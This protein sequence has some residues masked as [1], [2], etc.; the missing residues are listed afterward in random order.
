MELV[1]MGVL[2]ELGGEEAGSNFRYRSDMSARPSPLPFAS[3][4]LREKSNTIS[5]KHS[6]HHRTTSTST[7]AMLERRGSQHASAVLSPTS[8]THGRSRS[9][10]GIT[11]GGGSGGSVPM[12]PGASLGSPM[13]GG[14]SEQVWADIQAR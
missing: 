14:G 2:L 6:T 3:T 8:S 5:R 13:M 10:G 9:V 12:S 1:V 7:H 11:F 4:R